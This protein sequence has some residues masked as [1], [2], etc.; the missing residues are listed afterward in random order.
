MAA[1]TLGLGTVI[2]VDDNDSGSVFTSIQLTVSAQAPPR[3][4]V[5]IDATTLGASL[6][7][8]KLGIEDKSDAT[9][10][11]YEEPNDTQHAMLRT[12]AATK[13]PVLWN[14]PYASGDVETFDALLVS[15]VPAEI[16]IAG[17]I[18]ATYTLHRVAAIAYT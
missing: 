17:L 3:S 11:V 1:P 13:N 16:Q 12:L 6:A 14:I 5:R 15:I 10:T 8:D 4:W 7:I 9:F 2:G 18:G